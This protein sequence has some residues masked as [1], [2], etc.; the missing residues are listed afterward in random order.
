MEDIDYE[1]T[2]IEAEEDQ[3]IVCWDGS[4]D[5]D[6]SVADAAQEVLDSF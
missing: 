1:L 6:T 2:L 5:E 3:D 4:D